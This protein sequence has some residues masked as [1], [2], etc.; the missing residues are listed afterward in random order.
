MKKNLLVTLA[1]KNYIEQAKQLFSSVYW[2]AGWKGDYMLLAH[3]IPEKKLKWFREKG[4]LI[5]KCKSFLCLESLK[6]GRWPPVIFSKLYLFSSDFKK[7]RKIVF[8]D[9]DIIVRASLDNLTEVGGFAAVKGHSNLSKVFFDQLQIRIEGRNRGIFGRLKKRYNLK[10]P[11]FSSG[12]MA[13]D[14]DIIKIE[15]FF[16]LERLLNS[17]FEISPVDDGILNLYFYRRW[18]RLPSVYKVN[19]DYLIK[20]WGIKPEKIDAIILHFYSQKPWSPKSHFYEEWKTNLEKAELIDIKKVP[21]A[22]KIWTKQEIQK[23][24]K[25]LK[26]AGSGFKYL[27]WKTGS[28]IDRQIGISGIFLRKQFPK[29]YFKLKEIKD[30]IKK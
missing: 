18:L 9:A 7:W 2:N 6:T 22:R 27:I 13:F 10:L 11:S 25:N 16:E 12:L 26:A 29:A 15:S 17:Y 23:Y 1:D 3:E 30:K 5:K 19:P 28:F 8:L 4:I 24:E 21:N 20:F 14:T